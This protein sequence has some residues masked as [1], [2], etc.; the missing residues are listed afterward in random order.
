MSFFRDEITN[1]VQPIVL[2]H[3]IREQILSRPPKVRLA[4]HVA[5]SFETGR[6]HIP[7]R[8]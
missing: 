2:E 3:L 5:F 6:A 8:P 1:Y 7:N 4:M